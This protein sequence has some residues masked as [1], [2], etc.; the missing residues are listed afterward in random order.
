M[1]VDFSG[2]AGGLLANVNIYLVKIEDFSHLT[3][4]SFIH[5]N[6]LT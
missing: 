2:M 5:A 1:V 6:D 3:V 4:E